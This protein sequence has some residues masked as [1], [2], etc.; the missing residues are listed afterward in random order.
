MKHFLLILTLLL[1]PFMLFASNDD[2]SKS[3]GTTQMAITELTPSP[4]QEDVS[5]NTKIEVTFSVLLDASAIKEHD[6]KLTYLS[7]KTN[8][9]IAGTISYSQTEKKL[10][11]TP[12][13]SL[14][15]GL[16]EVE[17]KSLKADKAHKETKIK[18]IKYR[19][20]VI[21]EVLQSMTIH[22]ELTEIK[23]GESLQLEVI[24]H[25]DTGV[26]KNITIQVQWSVADSQIVTVDAN[27]ILKALKEGMTTVAAKMENIETNMTIVVYKEISGHRLPPEP[28]PT[29]NNATLLGIDSNNNGV[30]DDVERWIYEKYDSYIPCHH[31]P[32]DV[33]MDDGT[34]FKAGRE[35]CEE[36]A[37]PY[38]PIVRA[39]AMQGARAAQIIIQEPERA[40]ET[41][42][43]FRAANLCD[44]YFALNENRTVNGKQYKIIVDK[45]V[46]SEKE[47][48][49]G[50]M[51][52]T[53]QRARA[54]GKYNFVLSGGVYSG[55]TEKEMLE[56]CSDEIKKLL[57]ELK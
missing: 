48:L 43:Y 20:V 35:V 47:G 21:N 53:I 15:P 57:K 4:T 46:M 28:D 52:N 19:F 49:I 42:K 9:H 44:V 51:F 31:E 8:E 16:Y 30:R 6:V 18:E 11:F 10:T 56:G 24:G 14:E 27:T 2:L 33:V 37:I 7:S 55:L 38:H 26:E 12:K 1:I 3:K 25:Y 34:V 17:I 23:E 5:R 54:Y 39:I 45:G 22:P 13:A 50:V 29:I 41:M 40:R 36:E 32:Y